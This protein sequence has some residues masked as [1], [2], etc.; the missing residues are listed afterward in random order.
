MPRSASAAAAAPRGDTR[1]TRASRRRRR[2]CW[3]PPLARRLTGRLDDAWRALVA[4]KRGLS[5]PSF[6][7]VRQ[8]SVANSAGA[9]AGRPR[10]WAALPPPRGVPLVRCNLHPGRGKKGV[11]RVLLVLRRP[12]RTW[13]AS[14]ARSLAGS[15]AQD[16]GCTPDERVCIG[17]K[18]GKPLTRHAARQRRRLGRQVCF[19]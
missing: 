14:R 5:A 7:A 11:A 17:A 18:A 1:V 10:L 8:L 13:N 9:L 19:V 6:H 4:K 2:S 16:L 15:T 12:W 3:R